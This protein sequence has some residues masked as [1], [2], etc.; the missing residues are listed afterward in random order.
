MKKITD[1]KINE[2]FGV[3]T[4]TLRDWKKANDHRLNVYEALKELIEKR[5]RISDLLK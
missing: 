3:P 4:R 2:V 1:T 5:E